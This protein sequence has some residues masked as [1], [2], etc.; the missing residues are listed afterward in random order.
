MN[1]KYGLHYPENS[2]TN[3][4]FSLEIIHQ[5]ENSFISSLYLS[6][7]HCLLSNIQVMVSRDERKDIYKKMKME[8]KYEIMSPLK[9]ITRQ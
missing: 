6:C 5:E 9:G 2:E 1:I 8:E 4:Y 3:G 7:Y